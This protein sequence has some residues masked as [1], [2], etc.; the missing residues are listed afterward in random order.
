MRLLIVDDDEQNL[1]LLQVLLR[2]H[3]HH[4]IAARDGGDAL[5]LAR[6]DP[7]DVII[8]DI[9]MPG[10]DGFAFCRACKNDDRLHAIPFVFYTATYTDPRDEEFALNLGAARFIRKPIEPDLFV[11]VLDEVIAAHQAG[12]LL[13][14]RAPV[15][16]E[17]VF[18][19]EYN[20]TLVRK[21]ETK[22]TELEATNRSLEKEIGERKH[23]EEELRRRVEQLALLYDAGLTLNRALDP[24]ALMEA[25]L[26]FAGLAVGADRADFLRYDAARQRVVYETGSGYAEH[27]D[28]NA[29]EAFAAPLGAEPGIAGLVAATR[30]PM[31]LPDVRNDARWIAFDPTIRSALWVPVAHEQELRGV[32]VVTSTHHDAFTPADQKLVVLFANQVAV[33]LENARLF[34]ET[35]QRLADLEAVNHIST[36]LRAATT[37]AEMLA[38]FLDETIAAFRTDAG[39]L[40]LYDADRDELCEVAARGWFTQ[41]ATRLKP[42]EGIVGRVF[43][44]G[45][46]YVADEFARSPHVYPAVQAHVP[47]GWGGACVPIRV[48]TEIIGVLCVAVTPARAPSIDQVH[49]LNTLAEMA[50]N[51]IHRMRLHEETQR[52]LERLTALRAIDL[53]ISGNF[54]LRYTLQTVLDQTLLQLRADAAQ[55]LLFDPLTQLLSVGAARGFQTNVER[56]HTRLGEGLAGRIAAT[57]API[58]AADLQDDLT[59][60]YA[61]GMRDENFRAYVGVPLVAKNQLKGVLEIFQRRPLQASREWL[62]FCDMLAGQAAIAIDNAQSVEGMQRANAGLAAAYDSTLEGWSRALDLRDE[63][64]EGH[65]QRV[66]ALTLQ[67]A[68]ALGIPE[69]ELIHVRRGALLHDIGKMGIPDAILLK[70]SALT[71]AEWHVMRQHPVYAYQL[72]AP[73]SYLHLALDIPYC[74]HER[75]DGTGYPRGLK[76]DAI[77]LVARLFAVVDVW[78]ALRSNRP[79]RQAWT[80]DQVRAYLREQSGK[81]FDPQV[82]QAFLTMVDD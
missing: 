42:G 76:G 21:L 27:A 37:L 7:P 35:R 78:D 18:F 33:A 43:V 53:A 48:T 13:A 79:Y 68:R 66:V 12:R 52:G 29:L 15:T 75:W 56:A 60:W 38:R 77:P 45:E 57:R 72:L 59:A 36:S 61:V 31:Y 25:L 40:A 8:S 23:I 2:A 20:A 80:Q 11:Q 63:E 19:K 17:T 24:R 46:T 47:L 1:Y 44:T 14:P 70:P 69:S 74:H 28:L 67:L 62:N 16:E 5:A 3:N 26:H 50:G 73:I 9:L 81:Q 10:M 34:A 4:V 58:Q 65:T 30:A 64:T 22:M 55:I 41:A 32:L 6:R 54:D 82:V 49:L 39:A 51:A 71:E